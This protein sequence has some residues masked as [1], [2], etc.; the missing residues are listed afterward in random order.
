MVYWLYENAE[1]RNFR[2]YL[3]AVCRPAGRCG[4]LSALTNGQSTASPGADSVSIAT[5]SPAPAEP[6]LKPKSWCLARRPPARFRRGNR[7]GFAGA[8]R[9]YVYLRGIKALA[10]YQPSR[11]HLRDRVLGRPEGYAAHGWFSCIRLAARGQT[12]AGNVPLL[13]YDASGAAENALERAISYRRTKQTPVRLIGLFSSETSLAIRLES[14]SC[15]GRI[16]SQSGILSERFRDAG[17]ERLVCRTAGR[18]LPRN[19]R[20]GL[21]RNRRSGDL[22]PSTSC[23][24]ASERTWRC[25]LLLRTRTPIV[26]FQPDAGRSRCG[27]YTR[28]ASYVTRALPPSCGQDSRIFRALPSILEYSPNP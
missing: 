16:F 2:R 6:T 24:G 15:K 25:L 4:V 21:C 9:R 20:R 18:V 7:R 23:A 11:L 3:T 1:K 8:I 22:R 10:S 17:G 5:A 27:T 14:G 12:G 28:Q 13:V 19:D 26:A